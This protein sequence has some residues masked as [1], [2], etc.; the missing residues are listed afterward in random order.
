VVNW[1][2][3]EN[4]LSWLNLMSHRGIFLDEMRKSEK[5][6]GVTGVWF[7]IWTRGYPITKQEYAHSTMMVGQIAS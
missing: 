6:L 3:G 2:V 1:N 4:K 7:E 5:N